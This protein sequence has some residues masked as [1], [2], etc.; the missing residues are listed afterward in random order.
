MDIKIL[1]VG[2]GNSKAIGALGI[3]KYS[4]TQAEVIHDL[5]NYPWPFPDDKFYSVICNDVLEHLDDVIKVVE[6]VHRI[7]RKNAILYIRV[8]HFSSVQAHSD[9]THKHY[10]SS[11]SFDCFVQDDYPH[12]QYS[13]VKLKKISMRVCFPSFYKAV[14]LL[15]N[16]FPKIYER[17]FAYILPSGNIEFRFKILK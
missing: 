8:P 2:C 16:K 1:D 5:D 13:K 10:F 6:E 11:Q 7:S 17:Y 14:G 12:K 9:L 15:A 3:D 4:D